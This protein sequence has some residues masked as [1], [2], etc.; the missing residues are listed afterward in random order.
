V[1]AL[2]E[3]GLDG[4]VIG[5]T[6]TGH[7][8]GRTIAR[9][10]MECGAKV[11]GCS[12]TEEN[13]KTLEAESHDLAGEFAY[14]PLDITDDFAPQRFVDFGVSTYGRVDGFV[15]N[16]G[17]NP[18]ARA[19]L[20]YSLEEVDYLFAFNFRS[21]YF[22]CVAAARAM[23]QAGIKGSIVNL[24]SKGAL[25]AAPRRV[26]YGAIKAGLIHLSRSLAAEWA[27][28]GIRVNTVSPGATDTPALAASL[29]QGMKEI[30]WSQVLLGNRFATPDEV[31]LPTLFMLS[32]AASMVTG[33]LIA[34]DGG[35]SLGHAAPPT[36]ERS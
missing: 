25:V 19:A 6:G 7:G 33:Q 30:V 16:A 18:T 32:P 4:M 28:Y 22:C 3:F 17:G 1:S 13:L 10:A 12:R 5:V 34:A 15:N 31:A 2:P 35:G 29:T 24:A 26:P 8:I 20:D 23:I 36:S 9:R 27:E 11:F 21:V 14:L